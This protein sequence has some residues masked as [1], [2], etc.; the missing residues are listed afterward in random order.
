MNSG[1]GPSARPFKAE[2][3]V[4]VERSGGFAGLTRVGRFNLSELPH[5]RA[6]EWYRLLNGGQL[7]QLA[8]ETPTS[9]AADSFVYRVQCSQLGLDVTLGERGAPAAVRS[10]LDGSL[11]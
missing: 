9:G 10:L 11:K 3:T 8:R 4:Q 2:D 6:A 7:Q 1:A 5:D